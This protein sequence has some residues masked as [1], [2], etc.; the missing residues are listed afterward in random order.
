MDSLDRW[1]LFPRSDR[2]TD[3][4]DP[5][6]FAS[7]K[8]DV[9]KALILEI[10][11]HNPSD[12]FIQPETPAFMMVN[13]KMV[14]ATY[15]PIDVNEVAEIMKF[16]TNRDTTSNDVKQGIAAN[17]KFEVFHP[18]LRDDTGAKVRY[19]FRVNVMPIVNIEASAQIV[20]RPIPGEPIHYSKLGLSEQLIRRA[21][22]RDGLVYIAG[23]TGSGKTTTIAAIL[24]YILEN[25]TLIKG[26][27]ITLEDPIEFTFQS[28]KSAHSF[29]VQSQ[30]GISF[31]TFADGL[32]EAMRRKPAAILLGE[33]RDVPTIDAAILASLTGH[34]VFATV[35]ANNVG[36]IPSRMISAF[37]ENQRA[38]AAYNIIETARLFLAQRLVPGVSGRMVAAREYLH[39]DREVKNALINITSMERITECLREMVEL[40]GHS[41]HKESEDLLA[42]KLI[43]EDVAHSLCENEH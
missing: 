5:Y 28:I 42:Q 31:A 24:R 6:R 38:T 13:G 34:P 18:T 20:M 7:G 36:A 39:V 17:A 12:I 4:T 2:L 41:F 11:A 16:V 14:A 29:I 37:P 23:A 21:I 27:I 35:H 32:R 33:M 25:N 15:R 10:L 19:G 43:T 22:P 3:Y 8:V 1:D 40:K 26:N 30:L 9:F